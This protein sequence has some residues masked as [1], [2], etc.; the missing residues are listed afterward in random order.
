M[1]SSFLLVL[2]ERSM[3]FA[4]LLNWSSNAAFSSKWVGKFNKAFHAFSFETPGNQKGIYNPEKIKPQW[5][6]DVSNQ[7]QL[8]LRCSNERCY[9]KSSNSWY[10]KKAFSKKVVRKWSQSPLI[11]REDLLWNFE[12]TLCEK[13]ITPYSRKPSCIS[14]G[15][16]FAFGPWLIN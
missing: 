3:F 2:P 16:L 13:F 10:E 8:N 4:A 7:L 14:C 12:I 6:K 1:C 11:F 9:Y 15:I 5:A